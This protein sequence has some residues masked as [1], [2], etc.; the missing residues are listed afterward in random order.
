MHPREGWPAI[1]AEAARPPAE[2]VEALRAILVPPPVP[3]PSLRW[4]S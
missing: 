3:L 4:T 2:G 1:E